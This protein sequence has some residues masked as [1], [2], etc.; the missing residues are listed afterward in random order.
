MGIV[1]S[2][3]YSAVGGARE[4]REGSK[5]GSDILRWGIRFGY[6]GDGRLDLDWTGVEGRDVFVIWGWERM[7][8]Y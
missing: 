3:G 2:A 1:V 5:E 8:C 6:F 4:G 7:T